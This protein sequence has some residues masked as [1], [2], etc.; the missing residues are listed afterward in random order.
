MKIGR[1]LFWFKDGPERIQIL[2]SR[3]FGLGT[4]L[5]NLLNEKYDG[6]K[7]KFINFDFNTE[8]TYEL[9][10]VIPKNA[11]YYYGGHLQYYG[12]F[13]KDWFLSLS[14]SEQNKFVW[15]QGHQYLLESAQV[16]KNK[17]LAQA[18]DYA[19]QKGLEMELNTD[20]RV[21][22]TEITMSGEKVRAS[23]W[24]IFKEDR[25]YSK[26][27]LEHAGN[28]IFEK[29][30]D[31]AEIGVEFF[32]EIYKAISLE[33]ENIVIKGHKDVEYLPLKIPLSEMWT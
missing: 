16:M 23:I 28:I 7:I 12:V 15:Q 17:E 24:I 10:P 1:T 4:L 25:M 5:N 30:L 26:L 19:Y 21:V 8:K 2:S 9:F 27:T 29:D 31:D 13:D 11:P 22:D 20:Y 32:L 33:G 18:A 3:F 14:R 6:K